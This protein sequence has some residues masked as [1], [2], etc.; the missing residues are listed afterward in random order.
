MRRRII[1]IN[2]HK[3]SFPFLEDTHYRPIMQWF[4]SIFINHEIFP[5]T[6]S[7]Q[8]DGRPR[9]TVRGFDDN[10]AVSNKVVDQWLTVLK[11]VLVIPFH[12]L[13]EEGQ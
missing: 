3:D 4:T 1:L 13:K 9:L 7:F 6:Y 12:S 5:I 11:N 2:L 10:E 8:S